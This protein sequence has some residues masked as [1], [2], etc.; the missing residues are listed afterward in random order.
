MKRKILKASIISLLTCFVFTLSSCVLQDFNITNLWTVK[1]VSPSKGSSNNSAKKTDD[2]DDD[3]SSTSVNTDNYKVK[4]MD[5][6]KELTNLNATYK[7]NDRVTKPSR[8][9]LPSKSGSRFGYWEADGKPY[10]FTYPVTNDLTLSAVYE[11][12]S[13]Y[14]YLISSKYKIF[15]TDFYDSTVQK[16]NYLEFI[17]DNRYSLKAY[18]D[19]ISANNKFDL[20]NRALGVNLGYPLPLDA[21][22]TVYF[23]ATFNENSSYSFF[24]LNGEF[25]NDYSSFTGDGYQINKN[26]NYIYTNNPLG[27]SE[28]YYPTSTG[29]PY[30]FKIVVNTSTSTVNLS[31]NGTTITSD[32]INIGSFNGITFLGNIVVDNIAVLYE[33]VQKTITKNDLYTLINNY[34]NSSQYYNLVDNTYIDLYLQDFTK[35]IDSSSTTS[36][37]EYLKSSINDFINANKRFVP[38]YPYSD[39]YSRVYGVNINYITTIEGYTTISD[40]QNQINNLSYDSAYY[41]YSIEGIFTD[42]S[43][44]Y[45]A[46]E[47]DV[48]YVDQLYLKLVKSND[49]IVGTS[50]SYTN[51]VPGLG[52]LQDGAYLTTIC[53]VSGTFNAKENGYSFIAYEIPRGASSVLVIDVPYGMKYSIELGLASTGSAN[54]SD[55]IQLIG[56]NGIVEPVDFHPANANSFVSDGVL[57]IYSTTDSY[58]FYELP[59]G[60]YNFV[61]YGSRAVRL[62]SINTYEMD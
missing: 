43:L 16:V 7:L 18:G 2:I 14:D 9:N 15:N 53:Y 12:T 46:S 51:Q 39:A 58:V 37:L 10:D 19:K 50:W 29:V 20:A 3:S 6:S 28:Q 61:N 36:E 35:K 13:E 5:G 32:Q 23:E 4:F 55:Q 62:R 49:T 21:I 31:I 40:I 42:S 38:V 57:S 44:T 1:D 24:S 33:P 45:Y 8:S 27:G 11:Q 52:P 60:T 22:F 47:Y 34:Y 54:L 41:G 48:Y 59:E 56:P 30:A 17:K 25:Y 26:Y